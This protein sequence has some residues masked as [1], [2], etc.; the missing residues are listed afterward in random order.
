MIYD[1]GQEGKTTF[2]VIGDTNINLT[3]KGLLNMDNVMMSRGSYSLH[4][5]PA[6]DN[7]YVDDVW[8]KIDIF[9]VPT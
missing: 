6:R 2:I 7:K 3:E 9:D 5:I 8:M 1:D 4:D